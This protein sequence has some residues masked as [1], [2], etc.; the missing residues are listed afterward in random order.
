[1]K[2]L[3]EAGVPAGAVLDA[4]E[5]V[6]DPQLASLG[7][8]VSLTHAEAGTHVGP[9]FA[10]RL[11]LTPATMRRPAATMGEHNDYAALDLA[12]ISRSDYMTLVQ[13]GVIRTT[14]PE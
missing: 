1:M 12:E 5:V 9:R 13:A 4:G 3:Q 10:A 7:F 6:N 2:D 14:P 8:F 11:S